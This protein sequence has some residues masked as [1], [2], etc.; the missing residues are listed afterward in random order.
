MKLKGYNNFNRTGELYSKYSI[1][2]MY[3]SF[4]NKSYIKNDLVP[5]IANE[6]RK[7]GINSLKGLDVMDV[8]TGRCSI[9]MSLLGAKSVSH[10]DIS[11]KF[12]TGL[13]K[14]SNTVYTDKNIKSAY[15]DLCKTPIK[16]KFDLVYLGGI[17]HHFSNT[18]I[19][20]KNCA[21]AVKHNGKIWVYFYRSGTFKWFVCSMIRSLLDAKYL[22][23]VFLSSSLIY[24]NGD[25]EN[26]TTS[27]IM[28]DF[29]VPYIYLY[30]PSDYIL[31][32]KKLGFEL[33]GGND[34]EDLSAVNHD[35]HHHSIELSFKRTMTLNI[36]NVDT[37]N[38][39]T[40]FSDINQLNP[41][42]YGGDKR[43][44]YSLKL[45]NK[46]KKNVEKGMNPLIFF[47]TLYALHKVAAPQY[48]G[49]IELPPNYEKLNK[50]FKSAS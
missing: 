6:L 45:F 28:D 27:R 12:V 18:A 16:K 7:A 9:C 2:N 39:L 21:N 31:F 38:L 47:S 42:L 1:G 43:Q 10:Y 15:L 22:K 35:K 34:N 13:N 11:K 40:P 50:I 48:Y 4:L 17:V 3:D 20:L 44:K 25:K 33:C 24:S 46:F 30:S 29:F 41:F 32:M 37:G 8:G 36:E 23:D 19:G 5:V 26:L 49:G 14:L